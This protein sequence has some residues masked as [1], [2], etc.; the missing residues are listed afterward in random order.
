VV[1][2]LTR[3]GEGDLQNQR[4]SLAVGFFG[5]AVPPEVVQALHRSILCG[6]RPG[7][8]RLIPE[9]AGSG[10]GALR[11]REDAE[12]GPGSDPAAAA[13]STTTLFAAIKNKV[14]FNWTATAD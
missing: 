5:A 14:P 3:C 2:A 13:Y 1:R 11:R 6:E 4:A 7:P 10:D 9:P 8:R 12:S